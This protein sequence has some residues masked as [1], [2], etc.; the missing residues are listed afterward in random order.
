MVYLHLKT[1]AGLENKRA[2]IGF[3]LF[4]LFLKKVLLPVFQLYHLQVSLAH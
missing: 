2:K 1:A 4:S 3:T